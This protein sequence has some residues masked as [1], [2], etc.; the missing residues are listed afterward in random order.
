M[1]ANPYLLFDSIRWKTLMLI[2][3]WMASCLIQLG[4]L[5]LPEGPLATSIA[6]VITVLF[7]GFACYHILFH[8]SLNSASVAEVVAYSTALGAGIAL[9]FAAIL[10]VMHISTSALLIA[11]ITINTILT[12]GS[13]YLL[14]LRNRAAKFSDS[15]TGRTDAIHTNPEA[16]KEV[17]SVQTTYSSEHQPWRQ[18]LHK[19]WGSP[20]RDGKEYVL[21]SVCLT[22]L[23]L[24]LVLFLG[25]NARTWR[26]SDG[27]SYLLVLRH[28]DNTDTL[29]VDNL[30]HEQMQGRFAY[31][32]WLVLLL[33]INQVSGVS[34]IDMYWFHLIPL[35]TLCAILSAY[36]LART[37][38][39]N[40]N[41]S[42]FVLL[43]QIIYYF[44]SFYKDE[45]G[46]YFDGG[47]L[48]ERAHEDKIFAVWVVVPIA[49]A[50]AFHFWKTCNLRYLVG[51]VIVATAA[52]LIHPLGFIILGIALGGLFIVSIIASWRTPVE[53]RQRFLFPMPLWFDTHKSEL[54]EAWRRLWL[55]SAVFLVFLLLTSIPLI[56]RQALTAVDSRQFDPE[57][58]ESEERL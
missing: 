21:L 49:L 38:L 6:F 37:V 31:P 16:Y 47:T 34:L 19:V 4:Y 51:F 32:I 18:L 17:K 22:L 15:V 7:P 8:Q 14:E 52:T 44:A 5:P 29:S 39:R 28:L 2:A 20:V 42:L 35:F 57:I 1:I 46:R 23:V 55:Q 3:G 36:T 27:W 10:W 9:I 33:L 58:L 54:G 56:Q 12:F 48:V 50:L 30:W 43:L 11:S 53:K 25:L 26:Q 41:L 13:M 40:T 24:S 45:H